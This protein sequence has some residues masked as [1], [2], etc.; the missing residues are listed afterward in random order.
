MCIR[1]CKEGILK[2]N[3]G[4]TQ[5]AF[6][7]A[8]SQICEILETNPVILDNE[9]MVKDMDLIIFSGGADINP[10]IY[11]QANLASYINIHS[12]QRD[13]LELKVLEIANS[14]SKKI[15]GVCRGHQLVNAA[16]GGSLIQEIG[17][18]KSH[19]GYHS[20]VKPEG[21]VGKF[22]ENVNSMHHQG[23]LSEGKGQTVTSRYGGV[24]EST[25]SKNIITVQFHPECM[26]D[27]QSSRFF[28]YILQEWI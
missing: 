18:V 20:L 4:I 5:G 25:E 15:L 26:N 21:I 19:R 12:M 11:K 13:V 23:V 7:G 1:N 6:S 2:K 14:L 8:F 3:V 24:I 17:W 27:T 28:Q 9:N 16:L 10:E 22:F